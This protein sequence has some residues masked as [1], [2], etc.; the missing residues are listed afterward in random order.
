[1][2]AGELSD[3]SSLDIKEPL[4]DFELMQYL[5]NLQVLSIDASGLSTAEIESIVKLKGLQTLVLKNYDCN[6][7]PDLSVAKKLVEL[8]FQNCVLPDLNFL[9]A[10]S[11]LLV[12]ELD[13][14]TVG[15]WIFG[16]NL[17]KLEELT[18][19]KMT[20][21]SRGFLGNLTELRRLEIK[22]CNLEAFDEGVVLDRVTHLY[23]EDNQ[24]T[25]TD[26]VDQFPNTKILS[27]RYNPCSRFDIHQPH[28][29]L[30]ALY[31]DHN[32]LNS[33]SIAFDLIEVW[34]VDLSD[35]QF[36]QF[37]KVFSH[38]PKISNL[39]LANNQISELPSMRL[40][41]LEELDLNN[42]QI[43][44]I[45]DIGQFEGLTSLKLSGNQISDLAPVIDILDSY[46]FQTLH[47]ARNPISAESF[48]H[49]VP[50]ILAD[51]PTTV[52][53]EHAQLCSPCYPSPANQSR[54]TNNKLT[55]SWVCGDEQSNLIYDVYFGIGDSIRLYYEDLMESKAE[56]NLQE[57][58]LYQWQVCAK[59]ADTSFFS[60]LY[61]LRTTEQLE[62][63]YHEKFELFEQGDDISQ[64][65][66][67]WRLSFGE[68]DVFQGAYITQDKAYSSSEQSLKLGQTTDV[69]I[70][71]D[72]VSVKTLIIEFKLF[73]VPGKSSHIS[74]DNMDGMTVDLF[75]DGYSSSVFVDKQ[76][77]KNFEVRMNAWN[78]FRLSAQG[79][80]EWVHLRVNGKEAFKQK[81]EFRNDRATMERLC[82]SSREASLDPSFTQFESYLDNLSIYDA[83]KK[84]VSVGMTRNE[85]RLEFYP[86]PVGDYLAINGIPLDCADVMLVLRDMTG[87]VISQR[88]YQ[89]NNGSIV[90]S[91]PDL[92]PG[93]YIVTLQAD[94]ELLGSKRIVVT[95]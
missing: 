66:T 4:Q 53:P 75:S 15:E 92:T 39:F 89:N 23:L 13:N 12:L 24:L 63:P 41:L 50:T 46:K 42:N 20:F 10:V 34:W 65:S 40:P 33:L 57:G 61:N 36:E 88:A 47:L 76:F 52:I 25:T 8:R 26:I 95:N 37:P 78:T 64:A 9:D 32:E 85:S 79:L 54:V 93:L 6:L 35:N 84:Y 7:L 17:T 74:F 82:F 60:G 51:L 3:L 11:E 22:G 55:L 72:H 27:F 77:D 43:N 2:P 67:S 28:D 90:W 49:F 80:N 21:P 59:A 68:T 62:L 58:Q 83:N 70:D 71:L 30:E 31:L 29:L 44:Q 16:D 86:N 94:E 56:V 38:M 73:I 14:C 91:T 48:E 18:I 1:M 87:R 5:P 69:S 81:H 19:Q 45:N